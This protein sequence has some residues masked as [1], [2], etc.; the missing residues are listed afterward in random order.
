MVAGKAEGQ[1]KQGG[2]GNEL[3]KRGRMGA[4]KGEAAVE[5]EAEMIMLIET[6]IFMLYAE[7]ENLLFASSER[8]LGM[9]RMYLVR[10]LA[11]SFRFTYVSQ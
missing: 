7:I 9:A 5:S 1:K 10:E 8:K 6:F 11:N 3:T 4:T 2:K